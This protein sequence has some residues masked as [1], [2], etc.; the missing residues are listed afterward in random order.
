VDCINSLSAR[1]IYN[2]VWVWIPR[3]RLDYSA[4]KSGHLRASERALEKKVDIDGRRNDFQDPKAHIDERRCQLQ[5]Q[6]ALFYNQSV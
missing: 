2:R 3:G 1:A 4:G 5:N 6:K